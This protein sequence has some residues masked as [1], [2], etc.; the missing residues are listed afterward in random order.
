MKVRRIIWDIETSPNIGFFWRPG[1]KLQIS[2]DN[3]IHERAIICICYKW[4]GQKKVHHLEWDKGCD[5]ALV[6]KFMKVAAEADELVAHNGDRFDLKWFNG[7]VLMHGLKP[8]PTAKTVDTLKIAKKHFAL[9]SNRL[10]YIGQILLGHGKLETSYGM[11]K[12]IVLK[13]CPKAM[14]KMVKYCKMDVTML[15]EVYQKLMPFEVPK[16]HAGVMDGNEKWTCPWTG[17][18][19]VTYNRLKTT[20]RGTKQRQMKSPN[21]GYYIINDGAYKDFLEEQDRLRE[22]AKAEKTRKALETIKRKKKK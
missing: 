6:K 11:W 4:E 19:D 13:N 15:E 20:S 14:A 18:E 1:Y 12:D 16:S 7:R 17:S 21:G 22:E 3:I 9:N 8:M 5:K 10:D 2:H